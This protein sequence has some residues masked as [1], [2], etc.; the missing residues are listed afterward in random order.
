M[1]RFSGYRSRGPRF[2]YWLYQIFWVV[3]VERGPLSLVSTSEE[4]LRRKSSGCSLEIWECSRRD[5]LCWPC[6]TLCLQKLALTSPTSG[7]RSVG[8]VRSWTKATEFVFVFLFVGGL[9]VKHAV[10]CGI[11]VHFLW[12]Q[13]K[14]RKTLIELAGLRTFWMQTDF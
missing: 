8:I 6:N 13:G 1:V 9:H 10:Q 11:W 14:P 3:G 4:L 7:S 12:G 2:D 5:L